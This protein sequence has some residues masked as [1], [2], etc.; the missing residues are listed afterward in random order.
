MTFWRVCPKGVNMIEIMPAVRERAVLEG[1]VPAELLTAFENTMRHGNP[2]GEPQRKR[3]EWTKEAGVPVPVIKDLGRRVD[4]LWFVE[5]YPAYHPRG[6]D[7][8]PRLPRT[9]SA[10]ALDF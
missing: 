4:L 3:A 7:P 5:C 1:N 8:S 2:L 10:P 9:L 6:P